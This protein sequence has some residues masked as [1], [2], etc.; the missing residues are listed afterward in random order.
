MF[1]A[2]VWE[3]DGAALMSAEDVRARHLTLEHA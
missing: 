1:A 3:G 2:L